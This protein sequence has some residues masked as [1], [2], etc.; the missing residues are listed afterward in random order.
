M[1]LGGIVGRTTDPSAKMTGAAVVMGQP[2]QLG[3]NYKEVALATAAAH[4]PFGVA[5]Q[6]AAQNDN[7]GIWLGGAIV[8]GLAG[9]AIVKGVVLTAT[10]AGK[11]LTAVKTATPG[12]VEFVWGS[13]YSAAGADLD[14]FELNFNWFEMDI[15]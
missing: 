10:T 7:V 2:L 9:A 5:S 14:Y 4:I 6:A 1:S 15:A 11:F 12:T 3:T 13:A 8:P